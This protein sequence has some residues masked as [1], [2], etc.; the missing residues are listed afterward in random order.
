MAVNGG[1]VGIMVAFSLAL[2]ELILLYLGPEHCTVVRSPIV[3]VKI[4]LSLKV[5]PVFE[6]PNVLQKLRNFAHTSQVA[7]NVVF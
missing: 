6:A 1:T 4:I 3:I 2:N 5:N 7:K